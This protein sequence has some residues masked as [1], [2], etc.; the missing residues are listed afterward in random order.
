MMKLR[1]WGMELLM[2]VVTIMM[3]VM[4]MDVYD[5]ALRA[6]GIRTDAG[7]GRSNTL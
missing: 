5:A 4:T 1:S 2:L 7:D 3:M 6:R